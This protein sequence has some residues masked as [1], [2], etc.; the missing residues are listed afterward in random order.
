MK[1]KAKEGRWI[2]SENFRGQTGYYCSKCGFFVQHPDSYQY[3][4]RPAEYISKYKFCP[5]CGRKMIQ[6]EEVNAVGVLQ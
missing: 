3:Y 5:Q 6:N 2:G 1:A 4:S